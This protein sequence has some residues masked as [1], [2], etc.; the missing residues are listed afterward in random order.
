MRQAH[1]PQCPD[2]TYPLTG[3]TTPRCPECG[4]QFDPR[5]L[6][7]P[8]LA[9]PRPAWE[10][11]PHI[12]L[13]YGAWRTV[14]DVSFRPGSFFGSIQQPDR[15][16]RAITWPI[17]V[18]TVP[19]LVVLTYALV[20]NRLSGFGPSTWGTTWLQYG[21]EMMGMTG[22]HILTA[23]TLIALPLLVMLLV[24]DLLL[25]RDRVRYRLLF[26][27][28][29]YSLTVHVWLAVGICGIGA[30]LT[31]WSRLGG[32]SLELTWPWTNWMIAAAITWQYLLLY[33]GLLGRRFAALLSPRPA[34]NAVLSLLVIATWLSGI[35]LTLF[36]YFLGLRFLTGLWSW[37]L[38][39]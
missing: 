7:D 20:V 3:L 12:G 21:G 27:G 26:K 22:V 37:V 36:D 16:R 8:D 24:A 6:T 14:I 32:Q 9:R 38:L 30:V 10:R 4:L 1:V 5:L 17:Y 15:L 29:F 23:L 34:C 28:V 35:Y 13:F 2:C 31:V 19:Y 25:W 39:R 33:Y 11:R 18:I